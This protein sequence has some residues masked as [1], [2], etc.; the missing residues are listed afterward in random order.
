MYLP[1]FWKLK[2]EQVMFQYSKPMGYALP[3]GCMSK[4]TN[5]P[6]TPPL[7]AA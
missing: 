4:S 7:N 5:H 1:T 2:M 3:V 6:G